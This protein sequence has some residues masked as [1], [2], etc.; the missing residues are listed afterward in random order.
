MESP[1][2]KEKWLNCGGGGSRVDT[3]NKLGVMGRGWGRVNKH[4]RKNKADLVHNALILGES[5]NR[6]TLVHI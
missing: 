3:R 6:Q 2:N 1:Q 4:G 5:N